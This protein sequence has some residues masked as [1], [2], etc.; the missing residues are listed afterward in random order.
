MNLSIPKEY[1]LTTHVRQHLHRLYPNIPIVVLGPD[2]CFSNKGLLGQ[3][4]PFIVLR[5]DNCG[6]HLGA[7]L[8]M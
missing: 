5:T 6:Y 4:T 7:K 1:E 2:A 3:P 8:Y